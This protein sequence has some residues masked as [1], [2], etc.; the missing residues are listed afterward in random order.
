MIQHVDSFVEY[1]GSIRRRTIQYV[2]II[3][4][5]RVD[6]APRPGEFTCA[7]IVC[8]LAAA[9]SMFVGAVV[10]GLWRYAGHDHDPA[11]GLE[12]LITRLEAS[13][14]AAMSTL[15]GLSDAELHEPR[16]TL[17]G[18]AVKAWRLLMAMVEHEIHHR[19]QLAVHLALMEIEPPQIYGL[20]VEDVIAL[21][22][23]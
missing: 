21:A 20:G 23:G 2:W 8:H 6:W 3:P 14:T 4:A 17:N 18:P 9:E 5:D 10:E 12:T 13:H 7:Q 22:T 15:R 11:D 16:P 1:F 19:S